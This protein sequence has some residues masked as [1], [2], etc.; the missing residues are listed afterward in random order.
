[1][2]AP[3]IRQNLKPHKNPAR[4]SP[5]CIPRCGRLTISR[6]LKPPSK[7]KPLH[8]SI[9]CNKKP[10]QSGGVFNP[11]NP[12]KSRQK[13]FLNRFCLGVLPAE[14]FHTTGRIQHLLLAGE[15]RMA[16]RANFYV[17]ISTMGRPRRKV[18]AASAQDANLIVC[19]MNGC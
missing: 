1:M 16:I 4:Y 5:A 11:Y 10:H 9:C 2:S 19:G 14:A 13:L 17:D 6:H 18:V 7:P 12:R 8:W 3:S 15:E